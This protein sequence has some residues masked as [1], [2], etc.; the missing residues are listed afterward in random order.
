MGVELAEV[1]GVSLSLRIFGKYGVAEV[2][3]TFE[4][5]FE[6]V[7]VIVADLEALGDIVKLNVGVW[8]K[9][10]LGLVFDLA[11]GARL[12]DASAFGSRI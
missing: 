5:N 4:S 12:F 6:T 10:T 1:A 8:I 3:G 2:D 7:G 9:L 11:V